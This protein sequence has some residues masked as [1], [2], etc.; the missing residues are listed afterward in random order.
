MICKNMWTKKSSKIQNH[1]IFVIIIT[2]NFIVLILTEK[3]VISPR[4]STDDG[5]YMPEILL[6]ISNTNSKNKNLVRL[7]YLHILELI[8]FLGCV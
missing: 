8:K 3:V 1:Y 2:I 7:F 5:A 4:K 6:Y